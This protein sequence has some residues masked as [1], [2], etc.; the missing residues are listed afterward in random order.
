[1]WGHSDGDLVACLDLNSLQKLPHRTA[2][3]IL[4]P[5]VILISSG[6]SSTHTT[7][8]LSNKAVICMFADPNKGFQKEHMP[9]QPLN[10]NFTLISKWIGD[11]RMLFNTVRLKQL[12]KQIY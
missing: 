12:N 4:S 5:L 8:Y 10:W 3:G 2:F 9:E 11:Q 6:T 7:L 1:M